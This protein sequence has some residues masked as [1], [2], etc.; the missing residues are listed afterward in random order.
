MPMP[1]IV[2]PPTSDILKVRELID[3]GVIDFIDARFTVSGLGKWEADVEAMLL[4]KSGDPR[5]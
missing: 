3:Q 4:L 5:Y 2:L 1:N